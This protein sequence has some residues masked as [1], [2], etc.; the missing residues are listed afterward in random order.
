MRGI[1]LSILGLCAL[2]TGAALAPFITK[3]PF[4]PAIGGRNMP[5]KRDGL[6]SC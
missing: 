2:Y 5:L 4:L 6:F 1:I 3:E